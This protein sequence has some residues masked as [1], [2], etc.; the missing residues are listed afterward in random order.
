M[1]K[2]FPDIEE[3][4]RFAAERFVEIA[5]GAIEKNGRFTVSL[6]G[7]STPKALYRLLASPEFANKTD[8]SK[9]FFFFGDERNVPTDDEES[10]FRM[11]RENLLEPLNIPENQIF[12]WKTELN[13]AEKIAADYEE[14][15]VSYFRPIR[16]NQEPEEFHLFDLMILGMGADGH[17]ASI[18]PF[19]EALNEKVKSAVA[20]RVEKLGQ[21]RLTLTLPVI[22]NSSNVMFLV[23]GA[24]KAEA[25]REVLEGDYDPETYPAQIARPNSGNLLWLVD[26]EAAREI[27]D[28]KFK[29]QD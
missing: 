3:L 23:A 21:T 14:T 5:N 13:D 17:T 18:F 1:L 7:G 27:Q 8:W 12:R 19:T 26:S 24:E 25:L 28:S 6:A 10:N 2:V 9:V 16:A 11:A 15:I 22:R 4:N 29:I 20:N